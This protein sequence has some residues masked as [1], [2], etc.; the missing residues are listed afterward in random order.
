MKKI[1]GAGLAVVA[2]LGLLSAPA[3][4]NPGGTANPRC[5]ARTVD[6]KAWGLPLTP[7][8]ATCDWGFGDYIPPTWTVVSEDWAGSNLINLTLRRPIDPPLCV[9]T[10]WRAKYTH[11]PKTKPG[12]VCRFVGP[13]GDLPMWRPKNWVQVGEWLDPQGNISPLLKAKGFLPM[14]KVAA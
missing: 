6:A 9:T 4:A 7:Q 10:T 2:T 12:Q 13:D 8:G 14:T 1:I 5:V 11:K 3:S